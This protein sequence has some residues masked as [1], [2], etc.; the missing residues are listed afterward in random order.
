VDLAAEG[1]DAVIDEMRALLPLL[2]I[3]QL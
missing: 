2:G 1:A 3:S